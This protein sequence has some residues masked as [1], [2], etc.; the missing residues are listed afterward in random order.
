[1]KTKSILGACMFMLISL[2][3]SAQIDKM[4]DQLDDAMAENEKGLLTLRFSDAETD[5]P[6]KEA[7]VSITDIGIYTTDGLGI[8]RFPVPK[9]DG[10]YAVHVEKEGYISVDFPLEIVAQTIFYNRFSLSKKMPIGQLR[11][12]LEW[13][14][15]PDDL[16]AHLE[17]NDDYHISYRNMMVSADGIARLDRDDRDGF[18]PETI[19]VKNINVRDSYRFYVHDYTNKDKSDSERLSNSKA[20]VKVYGDNKLLHNFQIPMAANGVYWQ[21][22]TITN[23]QINPI[24]NVTQKLE[25]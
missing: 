10:T 11:V 18:G 8:V 22:F 3:L 16:D 21:V 7:R 17:K 9:N 23:G 6:V 14:K 19:T 12:V 24:N 20:S 1:M 25:P 5:D 4:R 15:K 13:D 2:S